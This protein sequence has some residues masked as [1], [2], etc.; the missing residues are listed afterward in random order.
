[1]ITQHAGAGTRG[2]LAT[3]SK[4]IGRVVLGPRRVGHQYARI[5]A[6]RDGSGLIELFDA[7]TG[8]WCD[9]LERCSFSEI[10]SAP[11][12]TAPLAFLI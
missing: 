11:P 4:T 8:R 3:P 12:P 5:V 7:E 2:I 10:W 1:M 6:H 9:A